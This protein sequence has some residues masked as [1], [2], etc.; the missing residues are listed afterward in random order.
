MRNGEFLIT[1]GLIG[2]IA[3]LL[4]IAAIFAWG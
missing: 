3:G 2:L 4:M 1:A